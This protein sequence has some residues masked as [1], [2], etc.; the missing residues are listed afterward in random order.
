ML[1][2]VIVVIHQYAVCRTFHIL[3]LSAAQCPPEYGANRKY[4]HEGKGDQQV[5]NIHGPAILI[6]ARH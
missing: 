6:A 1:T 2:G 5:K 4:Q 3:K